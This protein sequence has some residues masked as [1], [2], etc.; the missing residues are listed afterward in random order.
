MVET[1]LALEPAAPPG[2]EKIT[3]V[4]GWALFV[5][6]VAVIVGILASGAWL[7]I[8]KMSSGSTRN[9]TMMLVGCVA[10]AIILV[11]GT[12][13]FSQITGWSVV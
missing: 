8:E 11:S 4:V 6:S 7:A 9:A 3:M 2:S 10:G 13:I 5:L 12:A 1:L